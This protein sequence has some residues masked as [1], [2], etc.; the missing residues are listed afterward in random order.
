MESRKR[1][2]T[3]D[4]DLAR[5]S[6]K[7]ALASPTSDTHEASGYING[8]SSTNPSYDAEEPR[9]DDK[10]EAF[11]KD[12]I[13]RRMKHYSRESQRSQS[14]IAE[15]ERRRN[16]C[17]AG[18][19]AIEACW[20]QLLETIHSIVHAD[21]LP[22]VG[23]E[24]QDIFDLSA[25]V[26][27]DS[28]LVYVEQLKT[29]MQATQRLVTAFV[30]LGGKRS[31]GLLQDQMY[32]QSQ[33]AQTECNV[34]RAEVAHMRAQ[35]R[36]ATVD[37]ERLHE[38]L[39]TAEK[40]VDRLQSKTL[41]AIYP[42][43]GSS[44]PPEKQEHVV[45]DE[46]PRDTPSS[47]APSQSHSIPIITNGHEGSSEEWK[48]IAEYRE[49][50]IQQYQKEKEALKE[51]ISSLHIKMRVPPDEFIHQTHTYRILLDEASRYQHCNDE[52]T[53][54]ADRR[55]TEIE[56]L[57]ADHQKEKDDQ[58]E[59][60]EKA[61]TD[62]RAVVT[63][64]DTEI[65]RLREQR[66]QQL[67][68]LN[69]RKQKDNVKVSSLNEFKTL[70]ET[71]SERINVLESAVTRLKTRLAAE[72]G[73]EDLMTFLFG[74]Q[75]A[76]DASYVGDLKERLRAS[77]TRVTELEQSLSFFQEEHP[78][79]VQHMQREVE[80]REELAKATRQLEEYRSI[81][82]SLPPDLQSLT[83]ELKQKNTELEQSKLR[84]KQR[85]QAES[86]LY[87]EI[88]R[89]S[90]AWETL[91]KQIKSKVYDLSAMEERVSK[92]SV[93][94]AKSE[95]KFYSAMRDKEALENER[96][97]LARN[98]EKQNKLIEKIME[99]KSNLLQ[100]VSSFEREIGLLKNALDT[101][102]AQA[103]RAEHDALTWKTRAEGERKRAEDMRALYME[104][105]QTLEQQRADIRK[106]EESLVRAKKETEKLA[107][108]A[109]VTEK[110]YG[111]SSSSREAQLREE[112]DKC[113]TLLQCSTCKMNMRNTVITKC[114]HCK[115]LPS[116][117]CP[118]PSFLV[119][120]LTPPFAFSIL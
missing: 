112:V 106:Q 85:E 103:G 70:A 10:L 117:L 46:S 78:Q 44:P 53:A 91:D 34:L 94:K 96:K 28:D 35:L 80:A 65:G 89:L 16:T 50:K 24:T 31:P 47:P 77:E 4:V 109:K 38:Q 45:K 83:Q 32:R 14:K 99:E 76:E 69:E 51:E 87:S 97:N 39:V 111:G 114:M 108:K 118:P 3:E 30:Q 17:E 25:H 37:K 20:S 119:S 36:D 18:L 43:Q 93:D 56:K 67:S 59:L 88:D 33:K 15:L 66:D 95:N 19:A 81:L 1:E 6:K 42:T 11:R 98:G 64:R 120:V 104:H 29:K 101:Q 107:A 2:R 52:L 63:K 12:A 57:K 26:T 62:F 13:Y 58:L 113:M 90:A 5:G 92:L 110:A 7:R 55:R 54:E 60:Y 68:E 86:S 115:C 61:L 9:D 74:Q 102:K 105:E 8:A 23:V 71:R 49:E 84:E 48:A 21:D 75:G 27:E 116:P 82:P 22:P 72:A 73:D 79:V 40:R 100:Q 41:A